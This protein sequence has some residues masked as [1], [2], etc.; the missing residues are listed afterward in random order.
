MTDSILSRIIVGNS[1][2]GASGYW[3]D[4]AGRFWNEYR[5]RIEGITGKQEMTLVLKD[6]LQEEK[7]CKEKYWSS[8]QRLILIQKIIHSGNELKASFGGGSFIGY[9]IQRKNFLDQTL[10]AK[11][12]PS[13]EPSE[14][15]GIFVMSNELGVEWGDTRTWLPGNSELIDP[16]SDEK[17]A[18]ESIIF[19]FSW[20]DTL[21]LVLSK[22]VDEMRQAELESS[23]LN[24]KLDQLQFKRSIAKAV[25]WSWS[26]NPSVPDWKKVIA[27]SDT[28]SCT[29]LNKERMIEIGRY[30]I[31]EAKKAGQPIS[32]C[33]TLDFKTKTALFNR[34]WKDLYSDQKS[35]KGV[36]TAFN[37]CKCLE[38]DDRVNVQSGL[39][40]TIRNA[41]CFAISHDQDLKSQYPDALSDCRDK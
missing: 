34:L 15:A 1:V 31:Q 2:S 41:I 40:E 22:I 38:K 28:A 25:V 33:G 17:D 8:K 35:S 6:Q 29:G 24:S 14:P 18:E 27:D 37:K 20:G 30:L 36:K 32:D 12:S 21:D 7:R 23:K 10:D 39:Q 9:V 5:K 26:Q 4:K 13:T 3:Y 19:P 11:T 16:H